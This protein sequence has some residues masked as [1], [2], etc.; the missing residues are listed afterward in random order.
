LFRRWRKAAR[1][2][3]GSNHIIT[4]TTDFG[5]SHYEGILK[6]VI[7][8]L[9]PDARVLT[10]AH[11][12][13]P[14]DV[15]GAAFVM[16]TTLPFYPYG[17]HMGIV[18][19]TV[20]TPGSRSIVVQCER[21]IL[22][23]PD[24]GILM[25]AARE[26]GLEAVYEVSNPRYWLSTPSSTF[27]ALEIYAPLAAYL[28]MGL[29]PSKVGPEIDQWAEMEEPHYRASGSTLEGEIVYID[30]FGNIITNIPSRDVSRLAG[31][32]DILEVQLNGQSLRLPLLK[33]YGYARKSG[34]LATLNSSGLLEIAAFCDSAS[35][36]LGVEDYG[37][38]S[39]RPVRQKATLEALSP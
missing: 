14:Q 3:K 39:V 8:S 1:F 18:F 28:S 7:Q 16:K 38:V 22:I 34:L 10:V 30:N 23:G 27:L 11:D 21:G 5:G 24:N 32:R 36:M 26:L 20:G 29:S 9:N 4:L 37:R 35:R 17:I 33:S 31:Y 19:P 2:N 6:A 12:I 15:R 13:R 25:P